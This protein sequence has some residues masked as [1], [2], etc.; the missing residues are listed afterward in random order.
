MTKNIAILMTVHNRRNKTLEC[1]SS[2]Y[3]STLPAEYKFSVFLVNDGCTD[4]TKEAIEESYPDVTIIQGNGNLFWN[5]GMRLAWQT[6][7]FAFD[8][9][10]Y[11][12]FNDDVILYN[13]ALIDLI[14]SAEG[15]NNE[16]MVCGTTC[17]TDEPTHI[18]YGGRIRKTGIIQP[19]G[20]LQSCDCCNGQLCLIPK[21]V[22]KVMG[23]NDPLFHHGFGDWDYG[24]RAKK[25]NI[26]ILVAPR[27][28]G[29]CD[30]N[31]NDTFPPYLN[32]NYTLRRRLKILY[33]PTGKNPYQTFVYTYRHNSLISA[34]ITYIMLHIEV[35]FISINSKNNK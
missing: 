11:V 19:N 31:S 32:P 18:T 4:G 29:T 3:A 9:D 26:D 14:Q 27:L 1:L 35:F 15:T 23:M 34:L 28:S 25:K 21:K 13:N 5:R 8:F 10:Y 17:S 6:A 2:L 12:W 20:H 33:S 22:Y 16:A 7:V 30:E 24:F